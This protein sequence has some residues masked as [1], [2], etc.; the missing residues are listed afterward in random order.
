LEIVKLIQGYFTRV[1]VEL[2]SHVRGKYAKVGSISLNEELGQVDYI[3]SDKTGTLTCNQMQF[4]YCVIGDMCYEYNKNLTLKKSNDMCT[5]TN[6]NLNLHKFTD[7]DSRLRDDNI[8]H[9]GMYY[10]YDWITHAGML[11]KPNTL[12]HFNQ[13]SQFNVINRTKYNNFYI[14][15]NAKLE[16]TMSIWS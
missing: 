8:K 15:R 1:D 9:F 2:F 7:D 5:N 6:I 14:I 10:M 11:S 13:H 12:N 16:W 4:K 3:F